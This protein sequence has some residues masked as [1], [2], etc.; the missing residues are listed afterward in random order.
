MKQLIKP[1]VLSLAMTIAVPLVAD[2]SADAA[3]K[4][5]A[6]AKAKGGGGGFDGYWS[7]SLHTTYGNCPAGY[8]YP[9]YIS[10]GIVSNAGGM[11]AQ[12]SGRVD[13]AGGAIRR[14]VGAAFWARSGAAGWVSRKVGRRGR[15]SR[16]VVSRSSASRKVAM[17]AGS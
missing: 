13:G 3:P 5:A 10:R 2:I 17:P 1:L 15:P 14:A 16:K 9:V 4:R 7:V 12:I 8:R 11:D 6:K